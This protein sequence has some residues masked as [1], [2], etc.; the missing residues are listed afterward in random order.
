MQGGQELV[1]ELRKAR[2]DLA[3]SQ[4]EVEELL[5]ALTLSEQAKAK[6][7]AQLLAA[8]KV[9]EG[10]TAQLAQAEDEVTL[11]KVILLCLV[12]SLKRGEMVKLCNV[13]SILIVIQQTGLALIPSKGCRAM[14]WQVAAGCVGPCG[15]QST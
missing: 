2:A 12:Q 11:L 9:H 1:E 5:A 4:E 3:A 15:L 6:V 13:K 10:L 8:D 7:M 14:S